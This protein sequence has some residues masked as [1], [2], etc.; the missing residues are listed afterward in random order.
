[1]IRALAWTLIDLP[2][3]GV[4]CVLDMAM[5]ICLPRHREYREDLWT[6]RGYPIYVWAWAN[7]WERRL[8]AIGFDGLS[9]WLRQRCCGKG[10]GGNDNDT[11][12]SKWCDFIAWAT[13]PAEGHL[14][15]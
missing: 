15:R 6:P 10:V 14:T 5:L 13:E 7:R 3:M 8:D 12:R 1:M 4:A 9:Y 2:A 11:L